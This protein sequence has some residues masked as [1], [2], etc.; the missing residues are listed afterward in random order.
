M[1]FTQ[2]SYDAQPHIYFDEQYRTMFAQNVIVNL[3]K[4][5]EFKPKPRNVQRQ[6]QN[7]KF[8]T[9]TQDPAQY[10]ISKA[11][12]DFDKIDKNAIELGREQFNLYYEVQCDVCKE[13][14]G[15]FEVDQQVYYFSN[16]LPGL[17]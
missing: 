7:I 6:I 10:Q 5:I 2:I 4:Q 12:I 14:L 1:C 17:G 3:A 11:I 9:T 16:V 15:L 8:R 13:Q